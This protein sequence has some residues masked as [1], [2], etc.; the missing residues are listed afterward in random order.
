MPMPTAPL[1]L[2]VDRS[3]AVSLPVQIADQIR[4]AVR[5][6]A[7]RVGDRLP[8][9]RALA[10]EIGV[11]RA[12][13]EQAYDQLHAEGWVSGRHGSGTF[14]H[15]I[16]AGM[17][18]PAR[19]TNARR[20]PAAPGRRPLVSLDGGSPW[21]DPRHD[22]GWRRAWREVSAA[23]PPATYPEA[24]GLPELR[25]AVAAHVARHRGI[26]CSVEEVL[27]TNGTTHGLD[28]L[29]STMA[30]GTLA[31]EDPGYRATAAVAQQRGWRLVD[32]PVDEEG[33]DVP[34]LGRLPGD[35]DA[36]YTTPAHQH[37]LGMT[38][39]PR[40]R[41]AL[42][43]EAVRRDAVVVEDDYDSEFRYD[44]A[45]LPALAQLGLE[46]VVYLGTTSKAVVPGLRLGWLVSNADRVAQ[47]VAARRARHDHTSWPVQRAFMA[48]LRDGYVDR[49]L[50]SARR[51]YAVRSREVTRRLA[52][53]GRL[54]GGV[55]GMYT[56]LHLDPAQTRIA[57]AAAA[58]AGY[59]LP[60][61][62]SYCRSAALSGIMVG[63]GA[64]TDRQLDEALT[65]VEQALAERRR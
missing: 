18:A 20:Q 30:P 42:L 28:L 7:L 61:L 51:V 56:V 16:A 1:V 11:S 22:S 19:S 25:A 27:I 10:T 9:S 45:P 49:L 5:A 33:L 63:F 55:A 64:V 43:T 50:R 36:V 40:R 26:A 58:E 44:V 34:A 24:A 15:D 48:M 37:P 29:M 14:V 35:V 17:T 39:S 41:R 54:D 52:P 38:L 46:R 12:V 8:G 23:K 59:R 32:V 31:M 60:T 6:G 62:E 13:V 2:S 3:A 47:I 21:R 57:V 65:A 53:F 4:A